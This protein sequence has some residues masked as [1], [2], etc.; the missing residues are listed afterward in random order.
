MPYDAYKAPLLHV[1]MTCGDCEHLDDNGACPELAEALVLDFYPRAVVSPAYGE[2][3]SAEL[4]KRFRRSQA[5][6]NEEVHPG[7]MEDE[8]ATER[9][10][11][12][13]RGYK[14]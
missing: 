13:A 11:R 8:N 9:G 4:C 12:V 6:I 3:T 1:N 14:K 7:W 5:S 10:V 2:Q